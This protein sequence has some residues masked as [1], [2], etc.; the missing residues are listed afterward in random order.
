VRAALPAEPG[1]VRRCSTSGSLTGG[2][3]LASVLQE[4]CSGT[5]DDRPSSG[6]SV[7]LHE[8]RLKAGQN[9]GEERGHEFD[10]KAS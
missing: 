9:D 8:L 6:L 5:G 3:L 10:V 2:Q 4:T 1:K 7:S